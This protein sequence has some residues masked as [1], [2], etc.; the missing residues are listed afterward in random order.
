[1]PVLR[2]PY[3]IVYVI[4]GDVVRILAVW[5]DATSVNAELVVETWV[6]HGP[7]ASDPA[8]DPR[9]GEWVVV[10]DDDEPP[11]GGRILR[12]DG[13]KVWVQLDPAGTS[14]GR[15]QVAD[16]V[17]PPVATHTEGSESH[18]PI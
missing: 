6:S 14:D 13:N 16:P 15:A 18:A 2:F 11:I 5:S 8:F 12:R 17:A 10:G 4:T 9:A 3:Q 7:L 1:V